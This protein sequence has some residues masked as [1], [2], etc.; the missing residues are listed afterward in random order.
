MLSTAP[1]TSFDGSGLSSAYGSTSLSKD[2][3]LLMAKA[4]VD[5][6]SLKSATFRSAS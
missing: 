1:P 6:I 2:L 4:L 3:I 5:G